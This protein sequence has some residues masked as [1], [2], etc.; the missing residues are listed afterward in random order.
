MLKTQEQ[1]KTKDYCFYDLL[2]NV[3]EDEKTSQ[4]SGKFYYKNNMYGPQVILDLL[5]EKLP[6]NF[7]RT[8]E[9]K[10]LRFEYQDGLFR[11]VYD[12]TVNENFE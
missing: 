11:K 9:I 6:D 4:F 2:L 5:N 10:N 1:I 7:T 8:I 3:N 12:F